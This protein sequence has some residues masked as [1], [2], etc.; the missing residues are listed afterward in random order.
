M[1][2]LSRNN[3]SEHIRQLA[4]I[5]AQLNAAESR[6]ADDAMQSNYLQG[7]VQT[8]ISDMFAELASTNNI[9]AQSIQEANSW[10]QQ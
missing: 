6:C 5:S 7:E 10:M 9:Q 3:K 8:E 1:D 4:M 2:M